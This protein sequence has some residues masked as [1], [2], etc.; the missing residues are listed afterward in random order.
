MTPQPQDPENE[1]VAHRL[2]QERPTPS[3]QYRERLGEAIR[4]AGRWVPSPRGQRTLAVACASAGLLLAGLAVM[5]IVGL[6]PL[7]ALL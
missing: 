2:S 6:G 7:A 5:S 4:S 1:E 3:R